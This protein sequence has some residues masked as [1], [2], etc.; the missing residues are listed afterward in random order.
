VIDH[1]A[2]AD[3]ISTARRELAKLR[4]AVEAA[5]EATRHRGDVADVASLRTWRDGAALHARAGAAL[6][7]ASNL[8]DRIE[9][10]AAAP[11][12]RPHFN[13]HVQAVHI[14]ERLQAA[15]LDL[16]QRGLAA[17]PERLIAHMPAER[18]AR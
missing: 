7:H 12:G 6:E 9:M 14:A 17:M 11:G 1:A 4:E 2:V 16:H 8:L 3:A 10:A 18:I 13:L 5:V 15:R